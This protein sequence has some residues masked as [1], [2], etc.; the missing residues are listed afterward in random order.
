MITTFSWPLHFCS[1]EGL[2]LSRPIWNKKI[3]QLQTWPKKR[4]TEKKNQ[5]KKKQ[6]DSIHLKTRTM[7]SAAA[8]ADKQKVQK[9]LINKNTNPDIHERGSKWWLWSHGIWMTHWWPRLARGMPRVQKIE[10]VWIGTGQELSGESTNCSKL[11]FV[12]PGGTQTGIDR[13]SD[14][15]TLQHYPS[16]PP[17]P[18]SCLHLSINLI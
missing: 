2:K 5:W 14:P 6:N 1:N 4:E 3:W 12:P 16:P 18:P 7:G 11:T 17:N 13:Q 10:P 15:K 8:G 9:K